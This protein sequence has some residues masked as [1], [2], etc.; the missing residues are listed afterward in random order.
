M[1][2]L[3]RRYVCDASLQSRRSI[4]AALLLL[5]LLGGCAGSQRTAD[6][7]RIKPE[8]EG[9]YQRTPNTQTQR[10]GRTLRGT[11]LGI[12]IT[13]SKDA[14]GNIDTQFIF[15]DSRLPDKQSNYER[16]PIE[17][18]DL[19]S[20]LMN[21]PTD[22]V[23]DNVNLVESFNNTQMIPELRRV[24]I[25]NADGSQPGGGG[26]G[27]NN[28][29]NCQPF[30]F[31]FS[32]PGLD[33]PERNY[34][35]Y[36]AELR[37][38]YGSYLDIPRQG[39]K[40]G[41]EG[42]LGELAAGVRFGGEDEWGVGLLYNTGMIT[43][44]SFDGAES[45]RPLVMLHL[46]YQTPGPVTSF[47]GICMKPFVFG[48]FGVAI[49]DATV[50]L[51]RYNLSSTKDCGVCG[52]IIERLRVEGNL[53]SVDLSMPLSFGIGGGIEVPVASFLDA[54][55]D[56]GYRSIGIGER[57]PLAGFANIP[58]LRRINTFFF[59]LGVTY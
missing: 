24:P 2:Y 55:L 19:I 42:Y 15:L 34:S 33:C 5:L 6:A 7:L 35:W 1:N 52:E 38:V 27:G 50:N 18:V 10:D 59:R 29:C 46:R 26:G 14:Q 25:Y 53:G 56:V 32:I 37:S 28:P 39:S 3:Y 11:V 45:V 58:S 13:P 20:K 9:N 51:M 30:S 41:R 49:D 44:N 31:S 17:D 12:V 43:S 40:L 48:N 54:S 4:V 23:T 16:I 22:S 8:R 21:L 47:L 57:A 36:F